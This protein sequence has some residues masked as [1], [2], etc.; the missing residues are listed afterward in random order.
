M[1]LNAR[2]SD[3]SVPYVR[4]VTGNSIFGVRVGARLCRV[5]VVYAS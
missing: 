5:E 1:F 3:F 2:K 4:Q